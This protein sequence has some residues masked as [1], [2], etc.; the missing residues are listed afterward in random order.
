MGCWN[1]TCGITHL[2]IHWNEPVRLFLLVGVGD[3]T[4][5]HAGHCNTNDLWT[6]RFLPVKGVYS[7]Y[8]SLENI[9][10][11]WNTS[12]ILDELQRDIAEVRLRSPGRPAVEDLDDPNHNDLDLGDLS[13]EA[14]LDAIHESSVWLPGSRNN[15]PLGWMMVHE[16]AYQ[17]L[18][19]EMER[20]WRDNLCL[21]QVVDHGKQYYTNLLNG[22]EENRG[23]FD[24]AGYWDVVTWDNAFAPLG[25][26]GHGLD[27][28]RTFR[29]IKDYR[30]LLS[31]W[32]GEGRSVDDPDVMRVVTSLAEFLTFRSNMMF[33][34]RTWAPQTGKGSQIECME[35]HRG[36]AQMVIKH[37][38]ARLAEQD[39]M[40]YDGDQGS[41]F[42]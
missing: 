24:R 37:C 23:K 18:S 36:L 12:W 19:R 28:Y 10:E 38:D 6:P 13:I 11:D 21:E 25:D 35:L 9:E 8:G 16:W 3:P 40:G 33:L 7:D 17:H 32:A 14:V 20:D 42:D 15:L 31:T 27:G 4:E 1:E 26:R 22:L 2:P 30:E 5:D 29:G 39:D 41:L 34:R